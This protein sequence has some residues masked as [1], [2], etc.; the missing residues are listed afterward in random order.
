[1]EEHNGK[2]S[3]GLRYEI[4]HPHFAFTGGSRHSTE[5]DYHGFRR[6][7]GRE[8]KKAGI[9]IGKPPQGIK[10]RYKRAV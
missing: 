8:L 5:V 9:S 3:A 1:M 4:D 6:D 10:S 7:L 2:Q